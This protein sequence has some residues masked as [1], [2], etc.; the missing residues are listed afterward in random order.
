M[1]IRFKEISGRGYS[2]DD[3]RRKKRDDD[4]F[5]MDIDEEFERM[6]RRME[7]MMEEI[8]KNRQFSTE[9]PFVY[10]FSMRTGTDGKPQIR[11]FG[12]TAPY[13]V[14]KKIP[15]REPLTDIIEK[16]DSIAVTMEMPGVEKD[17]IDLNVHDDSV[18][19]SVDSE[20]QKYYKE[21]P[22]PSKIKPDSVKATYKNGVLDIVL[23][24]G[25]SKKGKKVN[26][27]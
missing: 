19:I 26:I 14:D 25:I 24:K 2:M 11:E 16:Q 10:G 12:N 17:D 18:I 4:W 6:R 20:H 15:E 8:I 22:L 21:L 23:K 1:W 13:E 9:K 7:R 3:D 27:D 5:G